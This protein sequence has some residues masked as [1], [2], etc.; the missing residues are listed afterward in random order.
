MLLGTAGGYV[1]SRLLDQ[2]QPLHTQI[3][4]S[5]Q[6]MTATEALTITCSPAIASGCTHNSLLTAM[7]G[8]VATAPAD[9]ACSS[10]LA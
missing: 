4:C 3:P 9:L 8:Q 5:T 1:L 6:H 7:P 2:C 10:R